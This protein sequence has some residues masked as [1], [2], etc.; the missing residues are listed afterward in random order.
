MLHLQPAQSFRYLSSRE[1]AK[2]TALG[3]NAETETEEVEFSVAT[4]TDMIPVMA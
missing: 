2:L 1:V 3:A 4:R